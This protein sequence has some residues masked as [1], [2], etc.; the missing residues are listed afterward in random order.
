M[1]AVRSA[2][3]DRVPTVVMI[4]LW[5]ASLGWSGV[6]L[7]QLLAKSGVYI[8]PGIMFAVWLVPMLPLFLLTAFWLRRRGGASFW[9][10]GAL[11]G[12]GLLLFVL[13][14]RLAIAPPVLY[15]LMAVLTLVPVASTVAAIRLVARAGTSD[16]RGGSPAA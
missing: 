9:L 6:W 5:L 14:Y 8:G 3:L 15:G 4:V 7:W 10:P 13:P 11:V 1:T 16:V 2:W 12:V